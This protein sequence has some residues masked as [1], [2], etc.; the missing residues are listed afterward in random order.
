GI[1]IAGLVMGAIFV[2]EW[3]LG[4]LKVEAAGWPAGPSGWSELSV[5]FIIFVIVGWQEELLARGYWLQNIAEGLNL[6]LGVVLSSAMFALIHISNPNV[7]W[8]AITGLFFAGLFLASGYLFTRQLWLPIGLHIGWNFFEGNV[9]GFEVSGLETFRLIHTT[10]NGPEI[11]TGGMFGPEAGLIVIPAMILG[12]GVMWG[13]VRMTR[14]TKE[15][16]PTQDGQA[17][18]LPLP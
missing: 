11:W 13:Y 14:R 6:P 10:V 12:V 18:G 9:F 5:W 16:G 4:W 2:T 8:I 17:R 15:I 7:S 3:R 1:V